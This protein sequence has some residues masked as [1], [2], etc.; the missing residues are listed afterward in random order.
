MCLAFDIIWSIEFALSSR[1]VHGSTRLINAMK[2]KRATAVA[3]RESQSD[4]YVG[5]T[6]GYDTLRQHFE[7][8][9]EPLPQSA[10]QLNNNVQ[11]GEGTDEAS[12][13]SDWDGLS[14]DDHAPVPVVQVVEHMKHEDSLDGGSQANEY[15]AFM[16]S[17]P[18]FCAT[19][20]RC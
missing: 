16:V 4:E 18:A 3:R 1:P 7:A 13:E 20:F 9:F 12:E 14:D 8:M 2:R 17:S 15:K 19:K 10:G 5:P 6:A 11:A